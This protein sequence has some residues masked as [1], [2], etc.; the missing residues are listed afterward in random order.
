MIATWERVMRVWD[1]PTRIVRDDHRPR[2]G[3]HVTVDVT[4]GGRLVRELG[5][6]RARTDER[7]LIDTGDGHVDAPAHAVL[8]AARFR[9]GE[10][11]TV[12]RRIHNERRAQMAT[13]KRVAWHPARVIDGH[14]ARLRHTDT[15]R[16][17]FDDLGIFRGP[18][19][20]RPRTFLGHEDD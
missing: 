7:L 19:A 5:I 18:P 16:R 2:T 11:P 14:A 3:D 9:D 12:A 6:V 13:A 20:N 4:S 8:F 10:P 15:D 17:D 1:R